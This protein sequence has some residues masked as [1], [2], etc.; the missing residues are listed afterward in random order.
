[1]IFEILT[2]HQGHK[3]GH[4]VKIVLAL[5]AA[6]HPRQF[7]MSHDHDR[8]KRPPWHPWRPSPTSGA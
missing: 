2:S 8:K 4:R 1:M 7:D 3:F 5:C 6:H